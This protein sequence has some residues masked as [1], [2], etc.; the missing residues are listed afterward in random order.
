MTYRLVE[1]TYPPL[2]DLAKHVATPE[3]VKRYHKPIGA[4]ISSGGST[5]HAVAAHTSAGRRALRF[6]ASKKTLDIEHATEVGKRAFHLEHEDQMALY[7]AHGFHTKYEHISDKDLYSAWERAQ[8]VEKEKM[9]TEIHNRA[10]AMVATLAMVQEA[11]KVAAREHLREKSIDH[12]DAKMSGSP[13]GRALLKIRDRLVSDKAL[14]SISTAAQAAKEYGKE[15]RFRVVENRIVGYLV[16]SVVSLAG[17]AA[18][19]FAGG[20]AKA[21]EAAHGLAEKGAEHVSTSEHVAEAVHQF[22]ENPVTEAGLGAMVGMGLL[23]GAKIL[24]DRS[25]KKKVA[26]TM[27]AMTTRTKGEHQA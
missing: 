23:I 16:A 5:R 6:E 9:L 26:R 3:G 11:E 19:H 10:H 15:W 24:K 14:D 2:V 8:G 17:A 22:L 7:S 4:L 27:H 13:L 20:A 25:T 21:S 12:W 1:P 18:G